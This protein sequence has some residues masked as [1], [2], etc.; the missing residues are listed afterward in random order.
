MPGQHIMDGCLMRLHFILL[1]TLPTTQCATLDERFLRLIRNRT[2]DGVTLHVTCDG[3][4]GLARLAHEP[5]RLNFG[6]CLP[7]ASHPKQKRQA[8]AL[9]EQVDGLVRDL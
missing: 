5:S 7:G 1:E 8:L 9:R 4:K 6:M 2:G 3:E